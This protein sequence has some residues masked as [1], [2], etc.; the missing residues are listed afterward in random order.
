[1]THPSPFATSIPTVS[2][3]GARIFLSRVFGATLLAGL[4]A[5][6]SRYFGP[7][8]AGAELALLTG[9]ALATAAMA[10]RMW[11][12]LFIAGRKNNTLVTVGPYARC[13]HPLYFF[14]L[15]GAV[16]VGAASGLISVTLL[17]LA[18]FAFYYPVVMAREEA[19]LAERHGEA[20]AA[21]ALNVPRFWPTGRAATTNEEW[22]ARPRIILNHLCSAVWFPIGAGLVH[23]LAVCGPERLFS[24]P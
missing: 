23:F 9:L 21:Y 17:V 16:G 1:M 13:R 22:V 18:A 6:R 11:C 3:P 4:L 14:N 10:G 24:L 19:Y 8:T 5:A 7:G 20:Y 15:V 2:R 12:S